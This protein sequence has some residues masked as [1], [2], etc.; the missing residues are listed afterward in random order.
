MKKFIYCLLPLIALQL[1]S[2]TP[3]KVFSLEAIPEKPKDLTIVTGFKNRTTYRN[4]L[5][6]DFTNATYDEN[7]NPVILNSLIASKKGH[8]LFMDSNKITEYKYNKDG[9]LIF[10]VSTIY[11]IEDSLSKIK[12]KQTNEYEYDE[13]K[14]KTKNTKINTRYGSEGEIT[15]ETVTVDQST[16]TY[17]KNGNLTSCLD[18]SFDKSEEG[19]EIQFKKNR[20]Y[21]YD[22]KQR[23]IGAEAK[24]W[25]NGD[26]DNPEGY[27]TLTKESH[28]YEGRKI[29]DISERFE[30]KDDGT[31]EAKGT[32]TKICEYDAKYNL[33]HGLYYIY[34]P[35]S[36]YKSST[37]EVFYEYNSKG[38]ETL[39]KSY[40][41]SGMESVASK[42]EY[43]V[44]TYCGA[45]NDK[46][47]SQI[48][49]AV[50]V[51]KLGDSNGER[52]QIKNVRNYYD[53]K[54]R[55]IKQEIDDDTASAKPIQTTYLF[56]Y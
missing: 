21:T 42:F 11:S 22:K 33:I 54:Q 25:G 52:T 35:N 47:E 43:R 53:N 4:G 37:T 55:V 18:E 20:T 27:S 30:R 29:T 14:N 8:E 51:A 2:C 15:H 40:A 13:H 17:D 10:E 24:L 49:T 32:E 45:N 26:Y 31:L 50:Q 38:L 28:K 48:Y 19:E 5:I 44:T 34:Y 3:T 46:I 1:N 41:N 12:E 7:K 16:Y 23:L 39:F 56:E 6:Y 36:P 9:L